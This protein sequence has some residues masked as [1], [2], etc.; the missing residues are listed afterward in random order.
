[1]IGVGFGVHGSLKVQVEDLNQW[2]IIFSLPVKYGPGHNLFLGCKIKEKEIGSAMMQRSIIEKI[3]NRLVRYYLITKS[4]DAWIPISPL[5]RLVRSLE[6]SLPT[7]SKSQ[8]V[9]FGNYILTKDVVLDESSLVYSCGVGWDTDF[10]DALHAKFGCSSFLFDPTPA[11]IDYIAKNHSS[12]DYIKFEPVGV[13]DNDE[14]ISFFSPRRGGSATATLMSE[15][16]HE[17]TNSAACYKISSLMKNHDHKHLHMLKM[18]IE[19]AAPRALKRCFTD[20][21]LPD[22]VV[23]EFEYDLKNRT[24]AEKSVQEV[25]EVIQQAKDLGYKVIRIPRGDSSYICLEVLMLK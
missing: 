8:S 23:V 10:E 14:E 13:W 19:G 17:F 3:F 25:N 20:N 22:Y 2:P 6:I 5:R 4:Q 18:D 7:I 16:S 24:T 9:Q 12:T 1:M 21:I 11:S 15:N